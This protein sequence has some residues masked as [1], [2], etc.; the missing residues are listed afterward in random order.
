MWSEKPVI[1]VEGKLRSKP[2]K[3][4]EVLGKTATVKV[5]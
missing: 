4:A 1:R 5:Q 3:V 2:S